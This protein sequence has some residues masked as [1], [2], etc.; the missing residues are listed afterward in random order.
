[1][2]PAGSPR[3]GRGGAWRWVVLAG[4]TLWGGSTALTVSGC[5]GA[6]FTAPPGSGIFVQANPEFIPAHGGVAV[7]TVGLIEPSGTYVPDGTTVQFFTNLGTIEREARTRGGFARANLVSDSRSGRATVT[8]V[9][10]GEAP[11]TTSTNTS[12]TSSTIVTTTTLPF[13][14]QAF[15]QSGSFVSVSEALAAGRAAGTVD[16]TIG[17]PNVRTIQV[18]AVP[19]RI[20]PE[21]NSTHVIATVLGPDGNPIANV[22]VQFFAD[23]TPTTAD[24]DPSTEFMDSAGRPIFTNQNGEAEDV[25]RTRRQFQGAVRV[26]VVAPGPSDFVTGDVTIPIL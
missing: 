26:R 17:N 13:A 2:K 15:G 21:S 5:A 1:M 22:P 19:P 9:S 20:P 4:L 12:T 23:S 11:V 25:V 16:V 6:L 3:P 8:A 7:I 14:P 10:G 24:L 18:R